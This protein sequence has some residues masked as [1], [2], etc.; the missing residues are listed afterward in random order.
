MTKFKFIDGAKNVEVGQS[1]FSGSN[2]WEIIKIGRKYIHVRRS[3]IIELYEIETGRMKSQYTTNMLYSSIEV[4]K[5]HERKK[6]ILS[7]IEDFFS[8]Y[9]FYREQLM[10]IEEIEIINNIV[11]KYKGNKND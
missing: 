7:N 10:T 6:E 4:K 8:R 9:G 2:E 11:C 5:E 1:V 3:H